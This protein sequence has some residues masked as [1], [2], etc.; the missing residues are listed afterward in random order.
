[1]SHMQR[2]RVIIGASA[3]LIT[4]LIAGGALGWAQDQGDRAV[5]D[6]GSLVKIGQD[7]ELSADERT[8]DIVAIGG[9]V[10]VRGRVRGS[11]TAIGGTIRVLGDVGGDVS[12]I[13]G[14]VTLEAGAV[15]G[16]DATSVGGDVIRDP[17]ATVRGE[18]TSVDWSGNGTGL[19]EV[20]GFLTLTFLGLN[21]WGLIAWL[22]VTFVLG[23]I[24]FSLLPI[25]LEHQ[26]G[27]IRQDPMKVLG[28]G[29]LAFLLFVPLLVVLALTVVGVLLIPV[30]V[31]AYAYAGLV[32]V[33]AIWLLLGER[34]G[35]QVK[36]R[37]LGQ[38]GALAIGLIAIGVVRLIPIV[39]GIVTLLLWLWGFGAVLATRFG[40]RPMMAERA[41][42]PE[43]G[44]S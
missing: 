20:F 36:W 12:A 16:G 25:P 3:L 8:E 29:V 27:A 26:M 13:G 19:G 15:V 9:N 37:N 42:Q 17:G 21:I 23:W 14:N 44:G 5:V 7:V 31:L 39:G 4:G 10:I 11:V 30:A 40:R 38:L 35:E 32:G 33:V 24:L 43:A 6:R 2:L 22:L 1:M 41:P 28:W 34:L 18:I